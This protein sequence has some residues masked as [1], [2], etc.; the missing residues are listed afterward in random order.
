[1]LPSKLGFPVS[2]YLYLSLLAMGG[3][4]TH[5]EGTGHWRVM[6]SRQE[7]RRLKVLLPFCLVSCVTLSKSPGFSG[8]LKQHGMNEGAADCS[9]LKIKQ[10]DK[11]VSAPGSAKQNATGS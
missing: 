4:R 7:G 5:A 9:S 11:E 2:A 8:P 1:M 10:T 3:Q 6:S